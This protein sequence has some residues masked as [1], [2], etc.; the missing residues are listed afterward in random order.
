MAAG[1]QVVPVSELTI[2]MKQI[3]ELKRLL[4]KKTMDTELIK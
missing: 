2:A 3:K 4:S 1:E